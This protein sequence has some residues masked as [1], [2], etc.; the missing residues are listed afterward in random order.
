MLHIS[1][2]TLSRRRGG[3]WPRSSFPPLPRTWKLWSATSNRLLT[4]TIS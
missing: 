2:T 1:R 4:G 3:R